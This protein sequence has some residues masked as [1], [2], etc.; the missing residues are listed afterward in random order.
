MKK[1]IVIVGWVV[2]GFILGIGFVYV[3]GKYANLDWGGILNMS[4]AAGTCKGI[5]EANI[6]NKRDCERAGGTWEEKK[7]VQYMDP[8]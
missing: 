6:T 3:S 1:Y 8:Y 7:K 4:E 2:L 5:E